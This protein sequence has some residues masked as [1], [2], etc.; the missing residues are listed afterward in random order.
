MT[1]SCY[2]K[3]KFQYKP[4]AIHGKM[5][6]LAQV[7][8]ERKTQLQWQRCLFL[9]KKNLTDFDPLALEAHSVRVTTLADEHDI[10]KLGMLWTIFE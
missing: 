2:P 9:L 10:G 3:I 6:K 7:A 1:L 5:Q 8:F 4:Y